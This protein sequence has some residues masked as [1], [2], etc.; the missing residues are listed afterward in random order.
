MLAKEKYLVTIHRK[1]LDF[2]HVKL[3]T[4]VSSFRWL[5]EQKPSSHYQ[6]RTALLKKDSRFSKKP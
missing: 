4:R 1:E 5:L 3:Q 2:I 6:K